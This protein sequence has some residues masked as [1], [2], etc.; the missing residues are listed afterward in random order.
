MDT[1]HPKLVEPAEGLRE[2]YLG[3]I[4]E[5]QAAGD[6]YVG[7]EGK[8]VHGD[9]SA[10]VRRLLNLARGVNLPDGWVPGSSHW[11]LRGGR[12]VGTC[13]LRH[14]LTEALLDFGG[15]VGYAVR[16]SERRKGY[17][18]FMLRAMLDKARSMGIARV[19][20]TCDARNVASIGV[21][22]KC[23]GRLDSQSHSAR[24]GR[25]TRRYWIEV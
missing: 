5:F 23:G 25:L 19:R 13:S 12:V 11:L 6:P 17:A 9:F 14:R 3:F 20:V 24:A 22:E 15:H 18:T 10:F 1:D 8:E 7:Q 16:P 4:E 21:I 2:A